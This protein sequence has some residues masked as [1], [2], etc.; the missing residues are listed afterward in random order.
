MKQKLEELSKKIPTLKN[1]NVLEEPT[2]MSL[3]IP[4][5]QILDYDVFN[6]DEVEPEYTADFGT[7]KGEKV[8]YAI[9][10]DEKPIIIIECKPI[11]DSLTI[12][13][14]QLFRYFTVTP[15]KYAILT[16]GEEY[17]FYTDIDKANVMDEKPFLKINIS[18][19]TDENIEQLKNF[20]KSF[21]N[22][23]EIFNKASDFKYMNEIT[24]LMISDMNEPS[25]ELIKYYAYKIY[26]GHKR[27]NILQKFSHLIKNAYKRTLSQNFDEQINKI[28]NPSE[29]ETIVEKKSNII[30]TEL[31]LDSYFTI[32]SIIREKN[33]EVAE[34]IGY[35]DTINYLNMYI[36]KPSK[37]FMR[38]YFNSKKPF[39]VFYENNNE[40][41]RIYIENVNDLYKYKNEI[42]SIIEN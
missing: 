40:Q 33:I 1:K 34:K 10:K 23:N 15:V 28:V 39:F 24:E 36:D 4:F 29:P 5:L 13:K 9:L 3:V 18:K 37:T 41:E 21:Y 35:K 27:E 30:T 25:E 6:I 2:K 19:L 38:L 17:E 8:D 26:P 42:I 31:E 32:K 22:T 20:H 16:N 7:K 14:S 11:N 12:H